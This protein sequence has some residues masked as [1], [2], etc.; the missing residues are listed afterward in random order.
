MMSDLSGLMLDG[1][2]L[3]THSD[4]PVA[5]KLARRVLEH[6]TEELEKADVCDL[7]DELVRDILESV[8]KD[9][10]DCSNKSDIKR[11][12]MSHRKH[13]SLKENPT[14]LN[15]LAAILDPSQE[16]SVRRL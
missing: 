1:I 10:M 16:W 12:L 3:Y 13:P 4:L 8:L 6:A 7:A 11:L 5:A 14:L 15:D 2:C 9:E